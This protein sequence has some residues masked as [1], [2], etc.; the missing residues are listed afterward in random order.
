MFVSDEDQ[1]TPDD[2][3]APTMINV[4]VGKPNLIPINQAPVAV[5]FDDQSVD[6]KSSDERRMSVIRIPTLP[7]QIHNGKLKIRINVETYKTHYD[8][9]GGFRINLNEYIV[10]TIKLIHELDFPDSIHIHSSTKSAKAKESQKLEDY[11][12]ISGFKS[13]FNK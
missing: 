7:L 10:A 11:N 8:P 9:I 6:G 5:K 2:P 4:I 12:M 3:T 13:M 1:S